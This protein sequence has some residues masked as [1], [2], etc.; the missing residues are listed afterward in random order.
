MYKFRKKN[1]GHNGLTLIELLVVIA[2][3]AIMAG[4][5]IS[6][7]NKYIPDYRL[8]NAA[9]ELYANMHKAKM[10][11]IKRNQEVKVVFD[12]SGERYAISLD[13]GDDDWQTIDNNQ[14]LKII[15]FTKYGSEVNYGIGDAEY[16]GSSKSSVTYS[17][18][19]F[20]FK[21]NGE[22][23]K[24]GYVY[25]KNKDGSAYAIG[26][27]QSGIITFLKWKKNEWV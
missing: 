16:K 23:N 27:L 22:C 20:S 11:A 4:M 21:S 14:N 2:I 18:N 26:T 12:V 25:L 17:N 6:A 7:L 10:E 8:Q 15:N 5:S 24:N 3:L 1:D 19:I 9:R 13:D